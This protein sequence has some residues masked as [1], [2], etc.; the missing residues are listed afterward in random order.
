MLCMRGEMSGGNAPSMR[1]GTTSVASSR[2]SLTYRP[3]EETAAARTAKLDAEAEAQQTL[4]RLAD[5]RAECNEQHKVITA[6]LEA[7]QNSVKESLRANSGQQTVQSAK[8]DAIGHSM[9]EMK[10]LILQ[11]RMEV[12][13]AE[14]NTKMHTLSTAAHSEDQPK[15]VIPTASDIKV[16]AAR[17][18]DPPLM[19]KVS[20]KAVTKA[21]KPPEAT[22][23]L[24][25]VHVCPPNSLSVVRFPTTSSLTRTQERGVHPMTTTSSIIDLTDT[26]ATAGS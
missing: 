19:L 16:V 26:K 15:L 7:M 22:K 12:Q 20:P 4:A 18:H 2:L 3:V 11:L 25:I 10:D 14:L 17:T 23:K 5:T 9:K 24:L 13:M 8:V 6:E 1:N 21:P